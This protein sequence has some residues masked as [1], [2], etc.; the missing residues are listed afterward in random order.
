MGML[1]KELQNGKLEVIISC[2]SQL[3]VYVSSPSYFHK[4]A[5]KDKISIKCVADI[6]DS[7]FVH[8]LRMEWIALENKKITMELT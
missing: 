2:D 3:L 8:W 7:S 1:N 6:F 5:L 4:N